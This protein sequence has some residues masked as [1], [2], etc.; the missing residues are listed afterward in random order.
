MILKSKRPKRPKP[1]KKN[2][3]A[4]LRAIKYFGE[5]DSDLAKEIG[6][7]STLICRWRLGQNPVSHRC[8]FLIEKKTKGNITV[9]D[10]IP[11]YG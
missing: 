2:C 3:D 10:L 9:S 8:A 4:V 7:Y 1:T 5:K 11:D 6:V